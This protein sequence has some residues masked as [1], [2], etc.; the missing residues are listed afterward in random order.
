MVV[1]NG[2]DEA[3]KK[4]ILEWELYFKALVQTSPIYHPDD[5]AELITELRANI[6]H[7]TEIRRQIILQQEKLHA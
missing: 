7:G 6:D 5:A 4:L 3:N 2:W 1:T